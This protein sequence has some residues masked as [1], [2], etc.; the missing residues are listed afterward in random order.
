MHIAIIFFP[1]WVF[2]VQLFTLTENGPHQH[3]KSPLGDWVVI[4]DVEGRR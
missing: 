4:V 2:I 1:K 3:C